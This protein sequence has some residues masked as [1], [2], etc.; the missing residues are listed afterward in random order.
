MH[1]T[2]FDLIQNDN[3]DCEIISKSDCQDVADKMGVLL[4]EA[5]GVSYQPGC[6]MFHAG[7]LFYNN[8]I[9]NST[10]TCDF[11]DICVCEKP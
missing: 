9:S 8:F 11:I 7:V 3:V 10:G 2:G 4:I 1:L 6:R 5:D